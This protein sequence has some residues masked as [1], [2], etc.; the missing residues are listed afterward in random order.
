MGNV[1][2]HIPFG[3]YKL[4]EIGHELGEYAHDILSPSG[5]SMQ[6]HWHHYNRSGMPILL[7]FVIFFR[8]FAGAKI[9]DGRTHKCPRPRT[10]EM[11]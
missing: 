9:A 5:I 1:D 3:G 8:I 7:I 4:F 6:L 2:Y 10:M 11:Q